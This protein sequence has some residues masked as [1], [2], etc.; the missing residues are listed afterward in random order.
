MSQVERYS[1][2]IPANGRLELPRGNLL[3]FISST[4]AVNVRIERGGA[5]EGI[6][7]VTG[8]L[9]VRRIRSWDNVI[10]IGAAG[11]TCVY[12]L[13]SDDVTEDVTDVFLQVTVIAGTASFAEAPAAT[14]A[15]TAAITRATATQ[16]QL[17]PANL[18]RRR[19]SVHVESANAGSCYARALGG[20]ANNIGELQPGVVY[21]FNGTYGLDVRND[22][23]ANALFYL[24]EES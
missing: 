1:Q 19:I 11:T 10:V 4:A 23:G 18:L 8:G 14:V 17:F 24:F 20:G 5:S 12:F 7:G 15:D 3:I 13:G 6:N 2:V 9:R 16:G 22:T 21:N